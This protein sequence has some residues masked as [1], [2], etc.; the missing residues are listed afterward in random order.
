MQL[1]FVQLVLFA[2]TALAIP[3]PKT[4]LLEIE[5]LIAKSGKTLRHRRPVSASKKPVQRSASVSQTKPPVTE[6]PIAKPA[7]APE[8]APVVPPVVA[9][10]AV[11][12]PNLAKTIAS[13]VAMG[14]LGAVGFIGATAG[15][16][17]IWP[18]TLGGVS[19]PATAAPA[20]TSP[21]GAGSA[22]FINKPTGSVP[23]VL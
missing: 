13:T 15:I 1:I 3:T 22:P 17:K 9:A 18:S 8:V 19:E 23:V 12:K 7:V 4:P 5:R 11:A 16:G 2:S 21:S 14:A 20:D 6:P 10:E